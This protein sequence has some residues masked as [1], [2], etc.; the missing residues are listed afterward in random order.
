[1]SLSTSATIFACVAHT[2]LGPCHSVLHNHTID[3]QNDKQVAF[4]LSLKEIIIRKETGW[5]PSIDKAVGNV[6]YI[7]FQE[8]L[9]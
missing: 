4:I 9:I 3:F 5:I 1:M 6:D 2:E 7:C 8:K